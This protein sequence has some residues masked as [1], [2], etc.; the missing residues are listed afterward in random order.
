MVN[1][2][3]VLR[4]SANK[5]LFATQLKVHGKSLM[6]AIA[7][8]ASQDRYIILVMVD[9][10]FADLAINL[11][12]TSLQPYN[13]NNYLF[14]GVGNVTC[15]ILERLSLACFHYVDDDKAHI[16]SVYGSPDFIRKMNIRTDM[17]LEGLAANYTIIHTDVDVCFL[18]SPIQEIKVM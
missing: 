12:E 8:R 13:I 11:Y 15:Q 16:A 4:L 3:F 9:E 17:I 14:V 2:E 5:Y 6:E 1:T 18:A 7:S 10:A